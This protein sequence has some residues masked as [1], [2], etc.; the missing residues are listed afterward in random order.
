VTYY[1]LVLVNFSFLK[2]EFNF[3]LASCDSWRIGTHHVSLEVRIP[4]W[5]EVLDLSW[6][7]TGLS[8]GQGSRNEGRMPGDAAPSHR[9]R[10]SRWRDSAGAFISCDY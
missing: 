5:W 4:P 9:L 1:I 8:G 10:Q 6:F 3:G 7:T 2:R